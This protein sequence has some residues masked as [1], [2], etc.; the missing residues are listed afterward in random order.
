[1]PFDQDTR[2]LRIRGLG[3]DDQ[4]ILTSFSGT[5]AISRMFSFEIEFLSINKKLEAKDVIGK[6]VT[7]EVAEKNIGDRGDHLV[8]YFHGHINRFSTGSIADKKAP[9]G[10]AS[11][12]Y[13]AEVVPWVWFLTQTARSHIFFPEKEEK[14]I[15]DII[16]EVLN[17]STH[18]DAN[19]EFRNA[20]D[21]KQRM[22]KHCVQYR[23]TDFNFLCRTMEQYGAYFYFEHSDGDHKLIIT[24]QP[25]TSECDEKKAEIRPNEG[26]C[27]RSWLH[28][29]E[30][31][32]GKFEHADYNFETPLDDLKSNSPKI[33]QLVPDAT[34]Y[35]IYDYPGEFPKQSIGET[36]ARIRQEAEEI[37]HSRVN[38]SSGY[39]TYSPGHK[40]ELTFHPEDDSQSELGEYMLTYVQHFS[41]EPYLD[42]RGAEYTNSFACVPAAVR[43]RPPRTTPKPIISGV[44][45]AVVTGPAGEEIYTDKYGRIKVCFHWDRE[46]KETREGQGENCSCWVRVAQAMAGRKYGFMSLP[47]INQEVV[48]EFL[49]GDPDRPLCVGSVY[50]EDQLPHY[51]PEEHKTRTYFKT[52]SSPGGD[53]FN[54]LF[55]E[56][57]AD[58]ERIFLHAERDFDRRVKN[59]STEHIGG[60]MHLIVGRDGADEG[61]EVEI[62][63]EKKLMR[64]VGPDG[65]EFTNEGDEK[66]RTRGTQHL[67]V[68]GDW[69]AVANNISE[70]A[71]MD[72]HSK[73]GM[74]YAIEAGMNMHVK[75]GMALV[76][77][78]GMQLTL[79]VGGNSVVI[80]PAGVSITSSALVTINGSM[81]NINSGPGSPAGSGSG[82]SPQAPA[83][84]ENA[85]PNEAHREETG[86]SSSG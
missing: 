6:P 64:S 33:E 51:N 23:E 77:E 41:S 24:T 25:T 15:S 72:L 73:S 53:G 17:R 34:T 7:L 5:E 58:Q 79:K 62:D 76:I 1:M 50:N 31:V 13:T 60:N 46:T 49:E 38:G 11:R 65:I 2:S 74:G 70:E 80:D 32:S 81:V 47:R 20:D 84:P 27:I 44:Q 19:W 57:K 39:K 22:V 9:D 78:S 52:N 67:T 14:S 69:N 63:V 28:S 30:F 86:Q 26:H 29:F 48:I 83:G 8:R 4:F 18:T 10:E 56:D 36:E 75:A 66:K 82:C 37:Q 55:F 71:K 45:T 3:P 42:S 43:Y 21:L 16:E 61:G 54:E 68:D 59:H 85:A 12:I 35:E 40:F